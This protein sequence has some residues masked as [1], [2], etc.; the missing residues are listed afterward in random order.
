MQDESENK[1]YMDFI[2]EKVK[3][4]FNRNNWNFNFSKRKGSFLKQSPSV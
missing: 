1:N 3:D 4:L 2:E